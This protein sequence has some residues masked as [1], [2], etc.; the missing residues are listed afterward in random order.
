MTP[1]HPSTSVGKVSPSQLL[2]DSMSCNTDERFV[3]IGP[4]ICNGGY[5]ICHF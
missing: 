3:T 1:L 2:R 5:I 4:H